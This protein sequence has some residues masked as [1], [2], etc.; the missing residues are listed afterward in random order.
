MPASVYLRDLEGRFIL[1]NRQYEEFWGLSNDE[2]RGRTFGR[3]IGSPT[4]RWTPAVNTAT[5]RVTLA[6][7]EAQHREARV[8]RSGTEHVFADVR[9]PVRD[10]TGQ[11]VAIAGIDIDMTRQAQ[12]GRV[13]RASAAG[14]DGA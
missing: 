10:S 12:P 6:C 11:M 13:G 4:S 7:G 2:I 14:R 5:D 9:F 3:R 8:V 1:V